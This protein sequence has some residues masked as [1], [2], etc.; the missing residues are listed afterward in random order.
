MASTF[1]PYGFKPIG[2]TTAAAYN[3]KTRQFPIASGYNTSIFNGDLV[4]PLT[5]GTIARNND[6][7]TVTTPGILGVFMGCSYTNPS[8]LQRIFAQYW[9]AN[10]VASDAVAYV[11]DDPEGIF[12]VQ[13]IANTGTTGFSMALADCFTNIG[14][15]QNVGGLTA[16]GNSRVGIDGS[17][18]AATTTHPFKVIGFVDSPFSRVGD[19]ATDCIVKYNLGA[20]YY[21]NTAGLA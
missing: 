13:A 8:T 9:P 2:I 16:T 10:T 6:T 1:S 19:A 18:R 5:D 7:T 12:Q 21:H 11:F 17:T 3:Q 4:S 15:R 14:L 20:H